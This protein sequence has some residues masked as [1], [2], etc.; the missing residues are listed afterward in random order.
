MEWFHGYCGRK[1]RCY[2][3]S[4]LIPFPFVNLQPSDP[5]SINTCLHF[6]AEECRKQQQ[7]CIVTFDLSLFIKAI[8]IVSQADEI[9]ELSNV[10]IRLGG[11]HML[12][13]YMEAVDKIMGGSG[14][15]EMWYEVFAKNAVAHMANRHTYARALRAHSLS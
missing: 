2:N 6:A 10:I 3:K 13:S 4:A 1:K 8:D 9:D 12:M 5:T 11:F 15:E 7:R 14:L